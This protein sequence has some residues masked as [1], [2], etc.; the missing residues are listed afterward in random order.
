LTNVA[1]AWRTYTPDGRELAV[2][3][4]GVRWTATCDGHKGEGATA[5][6][7]ISA[8]VGH[9]QASIGNLELRLAAWI[10]AEA[11]QLESEVG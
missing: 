8:A 5:L 1:A 2:E 4:E 7:A 3:Y 9:E 10:R 11:A 6:E